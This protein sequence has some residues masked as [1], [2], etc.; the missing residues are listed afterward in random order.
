MGVDCVDGKA[1]LLFLS[2]RGKYTDI[3]KKIIKLLIRE[4]TRNRIR[5]ECLG[6]EITIYVLGRSWAAHL[7]SPPQTIYIIP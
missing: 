4:I 3:Y 6:S 5:L 7:L 1:C 2:N